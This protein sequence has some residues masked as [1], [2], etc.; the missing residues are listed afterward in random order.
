MG[1]N[2]GMLDPSSTEFLADIGKTMATAD[3][4]D[5]ALEQTL[6]Q[7]GVMA[8]PRQYERE[9]RF[10]NLVRQHDTL[11]RLTDAEYERFI[12]YMDRSCSLVLDVMRKEREAVASARQAG[13]D[14]ERAATRS[15]RGGNAKT[16]GRAKTSRNSKPSKAARDADAASTRRARGKT[17]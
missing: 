16:A 3:R 6:E 7:L 4:P 13:E 17:R 5:M 11:R 8:L 2:I 14:T 1:H 15:R 9:R 10:V 12:R